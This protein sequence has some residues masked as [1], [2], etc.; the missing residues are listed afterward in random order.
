MA[1]VALYK[2]IAFLPPSERR[3]KLFSDHNLLTHHYD[4]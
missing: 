2:I 3:L 4:I 1:V